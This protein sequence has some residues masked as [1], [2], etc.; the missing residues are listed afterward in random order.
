MIE[1]LKTKATLADGTGNKTSF[2]KLI[3]A[4]IINNSKLALE[5]VDYLKLNEKCKKFV[6]FDKRRGIVFLLN[7]KK[8]QTKKLTL[9][10]IKIKQT[11]EKGSDSSSGEDSPRDG[12]VRG[13]KF[14]FIKEMSLSINNTAQH[15]LSLTTGRDKAPYFMKIM[16]K[17]DEFDKD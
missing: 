5:Q 7:V 10:T 4:K 15:K 2:E 13:M 1:T 3:I 6:E 16:K 8:V 12:K 14:S 17:R 9:Y 11:E